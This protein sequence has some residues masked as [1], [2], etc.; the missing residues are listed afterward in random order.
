MTPRF[1][2]AVVG[3]GAAGL[4]AAIAAARE[5]RSVAIVDRM[6]RLGKKILITGGGRCNLGNERLTPDLFHSANPDLV[7]S[8]IARF[9][10][11]EIVRFFEELGLRVWSDGG[12][13]YPA[14]N[15]AA[16][17]MKVLEL[18]IGRR[19]IDV[20][21]GFEAVAIERGK[22]SFE[23]SSA[24]GRRVSAGA[25]ILAGGG[26]SYPALGAN[27]SAYALART[28]GHRLIEPV[29]SCVPLLVKDRAC[30]FLQGQ[31]IRARAE[32]W[33]EGRAAAEASGDVLFTEYGLS[34]TAVLDVSTVISIALHREKKA[35]AEIRLDLLPEMSREALEAE[36]GR[37]LAGGWESADLTAGLLPEKF[38]KTAAGWVSPGTKPGGALAAAL[39]AALK[40][41]RFDVL[42]TRGWNEAEFT[43]GGVDAAEIDEKRLESKLAPGVF[44]AGEIC[45]VQGPRGG[46]NLSW[47]WASGTLAGRAAAAI[48][49]R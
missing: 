18:E 23:V 14:T 16:S 43:S 37:R 49:I 17:V 10:T 44:L 28:L 12:R 7:A 3:G 9:G 13:L 4:A 30:H 6:P 40:G 24:D 47:A 8:V 35:R 36:F 15:Q 31:K 34:G 11:D 22:E 48:R 41:K 5:G 38:G 46:Y 39:A 2:V 32:A 26:R 20:F 42:G 29:P 25:V 33:I 21:T 27:G 19:K 45:D 1:G